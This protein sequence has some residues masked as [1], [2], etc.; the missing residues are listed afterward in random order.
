MTVRGLPA[1]VLAREATISAVINAMISAGF[2]FA[3]FGLGT[4]AQ[5]WGLGNF[6]FDFVPQSLAVVFFAS[7]VPSLL[8]IKTLEAGTQAPPIPSLL[9]R[10][11]LRGLAAAIIG[12]A[13]WAGLLWVM[14]LE[15]VAPQAALA[16]KVIYGL[17]LGGVVTYRTLQT[18]AVG[19]G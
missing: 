9:F 10:S 11:L 16:I 12:G 4:P 8:A 6:A 7:F 18:L 15:A 17:L 13:I 5:V 3:V 1:A 14:G 2:F 19:Q